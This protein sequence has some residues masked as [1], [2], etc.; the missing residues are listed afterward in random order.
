MHLLFICCKS[1]NENA[2][3]QYL[4]DSIFVFRNEKGQRQMR[5]P[6]ILNRCMQ[7]IRFLQRVLPRVV[8]S[9]DSEHRLERVRS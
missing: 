7:I 6:Y 9:A 1:N 3:A 8:Q 2:G 5:R 4:K